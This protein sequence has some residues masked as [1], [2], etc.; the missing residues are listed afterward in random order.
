[1]LEKLNKGW[2]P[3]TTALSL[4]WKDLSVR[5]KGGKD[6][7]VYADTLGSIFTAPF[8]TL[9]TKRRSP[10]QDPTQQELRTPSTL[11]KGERYLLHDLG[12]VVKPG[13]MLLV[14]VSRRI[15]RITSVQSVDVLGTVSQGQPGAGTTTFLKAMA[16]LVEGYSGIDGSVYYGNVSDKRSKAFKDL[17]GMCLTW[18]LF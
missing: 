10:R 2:Q 16:G 7:V 8:A 5:G 6:E 14:L 4:A 17:S 18:K 15:G 11:S 12:G 1:M 3:T 9:S 13:E